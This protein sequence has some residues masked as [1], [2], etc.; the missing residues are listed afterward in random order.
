M[1][2]DRWGTA[3]GGD[4]GREGEPPMGVPAFWLADGNY[5]TE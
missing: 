5:R 4:D 1:G 3:A 2:L